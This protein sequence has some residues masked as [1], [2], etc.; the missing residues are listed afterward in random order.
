MR[1]IRFQAI[2]V[3]CLAAVALSGCST[4]LIGIEIGITWVEGSTRHYVET[5]ESGVPLEPILI[6]DLHADSLLSI[7]DLTVHGSHGHIDL[8]RLR[9]AGVGLQVFG[10]PTNKSTCLPDTLSNCPEH[11]DLMQ[12]L[13]VLSGR[14][15]A[16]WAKQAYFSR[17]KDIA[18]RLHTLAANDWD[19]ILIKTKS[20]LYEFCRRRL[21]NQRVV[22]LTPL[23]G[24]A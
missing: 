2:F 15:T 21:S 20:D 9:Q 16:A 3:A 8:P 7:R 11:Y 6:A 24:R 4:I 5:T 23:G 18:T 12:V 17:A 1:S 13:T 14:P 22:G 19:F 10:A